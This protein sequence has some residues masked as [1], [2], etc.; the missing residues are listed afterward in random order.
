MPIEQAIAI[1]PNPAEA[2]RRILNVDRLGALVLQGF[3]G[4]GL[5]E[6]DAGGLPDSCMQVM[7]AAGL[8]SRRFVL[9]R[10]APD[11]RDHA[12]RFSKTAFPFAAVSHGSVTPAPAAIAVVTAVNT[13]RPAGAGVARRIRRR[14]A[15]I[16]RQAAPD[17]RSSPTGDARHRAVCVQK[18]CS[19]PRYLGFP[20]MFAIFAPLNRTD[21]APSLPWREL[22]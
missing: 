14:E 2:P 11:R 6:E 13:R 4:C 19:G 21:P 5:G 16:S 20:H 18:Y 10:R 15:A 12:P 17:K 22:S 8:P 3:Q 7:P 1:Y 9:D